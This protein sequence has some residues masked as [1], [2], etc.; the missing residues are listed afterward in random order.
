MNLRN[1]LSIVLLSLLLVSTSCKDS[2]PSE[3]VRVISPEELKEAVYDSN[4]HQ[5]VDVRTVEEFREGH[6]KNAQNICVTDDDFEKNVLK[7]DKN[8]PVYLYCRS[9][10]RS[11]AAA[12]ILKDLGFK[13]IYDMEGGYLNWKNQDFETEL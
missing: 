2:G 13:E 10:K 1:I 7:L 4:P 9:G 5:L 8:K 11:A 3:A 6:L 12:K